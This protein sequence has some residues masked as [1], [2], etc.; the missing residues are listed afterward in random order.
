MT[1]VVEMRLPGKWYSDYE[2]NF[3]LESTLAEI[4][5]AYEDF[6][7]ITVSKSLLKVSR[8]STSHE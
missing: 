2:K 1:F 5:C 8:N 7:I 3:L 6:K 4:Y